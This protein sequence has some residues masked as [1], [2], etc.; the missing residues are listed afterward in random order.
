M[1]VQEISYLVF[2]SNQVVICLMVQS[3]VDYLVTEP[4]KVD[5]TQLVVLELNTSLLP[6]IIP[7][8]HAKV[9]VT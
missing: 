6:E 2:V 5:V 3:T 1:Q 7:V 4:M 9:S 8:V